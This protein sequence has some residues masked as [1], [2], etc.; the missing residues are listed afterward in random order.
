MKTLAV[1]ALVTACGRK[2]AAQLTTIDNIEAMRWVMAE[3][4]MPATMQ[5]VINAQGRSWMTSEDGGRRIRLDVELSNMVPGGEHPWV[6]RTGQC[7]SNGAELIRVTDG[8]RLKV[9]SDGKAKADMTAPM[10]F[11]TS[12]DYMVAVMASN[13]NADRVI[14]CGN[15]AAPN[16]RPAR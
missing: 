5:G 10:P 13:E 3:L 9:G 4:K 6:L 11:P 12:G 1:I 14:A 16:M 15:F 7:G 2:Q 8:N